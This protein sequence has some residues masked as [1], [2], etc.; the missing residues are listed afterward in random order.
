MKDDLYELRPFPQVNEAQV[1]TPKPT[2]KK[3]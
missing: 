3:I 2:D 1:K